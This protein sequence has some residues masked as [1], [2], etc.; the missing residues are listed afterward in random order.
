MP[1]H[2]FKVWLFLLTKVNDYSND[3]IYNGRQLYTWS[4]G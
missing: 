3:N 2:F 4:T 1:H